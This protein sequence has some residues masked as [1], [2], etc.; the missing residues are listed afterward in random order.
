[1]VYITTMPQM[2]KVVRQSVSIPERIARRVRGLAKT[3]K[4]SANRVLVD[5]IQAGLESKE[6]EKTRFLTLADQ[7][8]E[9]RDPHE[10]ESLKRELARMTFG[11]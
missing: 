5:L 2:E 3:Q 11:K 8:S 6:A 9:C 4:T 7:L 10:R 1:M